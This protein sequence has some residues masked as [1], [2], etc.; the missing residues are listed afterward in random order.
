MKRN[1]LIGTGFVFAAALG[2]TV[3]ACDSTHD[4]TQPE[5]AVADHGGLLYANAAGGQFLQCSG[6]DS[7]ADGY[8]TCQTKLNG[9][10]SEILCAY[11]GQ[12]G[13]K[14]KR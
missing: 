5:K 14:A 1:F 6:R 3:A 2:L 9:Q 10:L 4:L 7:D 8:V 11:R 13:C 12:P